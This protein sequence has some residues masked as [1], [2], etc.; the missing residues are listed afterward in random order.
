MTSQGKGLLS[1]A[2]VAMLFGYHYLNV[3]LIPYFEIKIAKLD[4]DFME[5]IINGKKKLTRKYLI[6][7]K[8]KCCKVA[9]VLCDLGGIYEFH[10]VIKNVNIAKYIYKTYRARLIQQSDPHNGLAY[11][12]DELKGNNGKNKM[13][14]SITKDKGNRLTR[15]HMVC[16]AIIFI[17]VGDGSASDVVFVRV[18]HLPCKELLC[19]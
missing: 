2:N 8:N 17:Q 10:P 7:K 11:Y 3:S 19:G 5:I 15:S 6:V 1:L 18:Y 16:R 13:M 12:I 14:V 4:P 9:D